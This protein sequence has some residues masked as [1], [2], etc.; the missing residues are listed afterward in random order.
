MPIAT[1]AQANEVV[2]L[3]RMRSRI[4]QVF[5]AL[6]SDALALNYS[7]VIYAHRMFNLAAVAL[8]CA[9][10]TI[11]LVYARD[12]SSRPATDVIYAR[13]AVLS[14]FSPANSKAI[15]NCRKIPIL[16]IV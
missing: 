16:P 9:I 5:R 15:P 2:Q 4:E 11:Q 12:V 6:K 14:N 10:R 13:F 7:Q 3:Y 8:A 1:A